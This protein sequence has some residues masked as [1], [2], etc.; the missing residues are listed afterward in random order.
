MTKLELSIAWRYL[1]S[2]R[3]S[4]LLSLISVIAIGGVIV[5]VSALIVIIGVMNGLQNDLREKILIGSPDIRVLTV[6]EDMVMSSWQKERE[7]HARSGDG[8]SRSTHREV[9]GDGRVRD[10]HVR[11]RQQLRVHVAAVG[12]GAGATE[13]RRDG[14]GGADSHARRRALGGARYRRLAGISVSHR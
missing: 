1:R 7:R 10:R 9:R 11:V 12:A 8:R 3:G 5:G 14:A 6:G 4:R 13:G 2:R